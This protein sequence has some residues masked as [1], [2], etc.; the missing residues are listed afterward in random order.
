MR[1]RHY[2]VWL[3]QSSVL[4]VGSLSKVVARGMRIGWI[5]GPRAIIARLGEIRRQIDAGTPGLVQALAA[6]LLTSPAWPSHVEA[7]S[8]ALRVRRDS[9]HQT[10]SGFAGSGVQWTAPEGGTS[11]RLNVDGSVPD[12]VR[13]KWAVNGGV[14]YAPG[15]LYGADDGFVRLNYAR[16]FPGEAKLGLTQLKEVINSDPVL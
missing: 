11:L 8:T 5:A 6:R 12:H 2:S 9:F 16:L 15:R 1:R 10:L 14:T 7:V 4:Y 13:L 3:S